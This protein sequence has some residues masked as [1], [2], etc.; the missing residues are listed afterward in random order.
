MIHTPLSWLRPLA[1]LSVS[2][3]CLNAAPQTFD[4]KD[5]KGVNSI[6]FHLDA[7]LESI[8]GTG[9]GISGKV[10]FDPDAPEETRG[11]IIVETASLAV[12]N[13]MMMQHLHGGQWLNAAEHPAI[14]FEVK[15][16]ANARKEGRATIADVTGELTIKNVTRE[17]S[18]PVSFTHLPD[19][20][21]ARQNNPS[22]K[23][24]LLVLRATFEIDRN[25]FEI[26]PGNHTDKVGET[27]HL[28]LAIAGSAPRE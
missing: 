7:P 6:L 8:S 4:F 2:A 5:P 13:P 19:Q 23:G 17:L 28:T 10:T 15:E 16:I 22:L 9:N 14:I 3:L 12:G 11:R 20:L 27:I 25:A 24:D 26:Q 1:F 21:G 18:V